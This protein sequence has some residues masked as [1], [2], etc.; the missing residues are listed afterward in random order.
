MKKK[1]TNSYETN[2]INFNLLPYELKKFILCNTTVEYAF[3]SLQFVCS[4]W[5]DFLNLFKYF[6]KIVILNFMIETKEAG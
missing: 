5:Y 6:V 2:L 1:E 4:E 3:I